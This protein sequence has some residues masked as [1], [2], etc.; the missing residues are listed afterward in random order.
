MVVESCEWAA[1]QE[2]HETVGRH[3]QM[4]ALFA[5]D[6]ERF[7]ALSLSA[8][9]LLLDYSKNIVDGRT[10]SLLFAL[11]RSRKVE[12]Q[13]DAMF[14]GE[15]INVTEDRA[16]L[17]TALR[18][19]GETAQTKGASERA[20]LVEGELRSM[21]R[22][23]QAVRAGQWI[24][25]DGKTAISDVV[26]IG[27]GGSDLGPAMVCTALQGDYGADEGGHLVR[28]HFVSNV[29]GCQLAAVLRAL[30]SPASTLFVVVSKTFTTAE[31]MLNASSARDYILAGFEKHRKSCPSLAASGGAESLEGGSGSCLAKH[32]V[33]VS[34][35]EEAAVAFGVAPCNIVRFWDWVGGRYSLWSA[36]G[37]TIMVALGYDNFLDLL[38]GAHA[39]DR[40]FRE[41][42]LEANMPVIMALIGVYYNNFWRCQTHAVLPYE[43]R[44][45]RFPAYLQQADMESNGKGTTLEGQLIGNAYETGPIVWGEPGTNGQHAFYQLLHQGT[46]V[47][48]AD[49]LIG[50][51]TSA[52]A[53]AMSG[54]KHHRMLAA[55]CFAQS[56][57]LMVGSSGNGDAHKAFPGNRPSNTLVYDRLTPS[58]LGSL[59]ALYEHKIFVQGVI[60]GVN[61]FDQMG[62]E[63]G[64][65]LATRILGELEGSSSSASPADL[66]ALGGHDSSTAAL[67]AHFLAQRAHA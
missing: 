31:T 2:H 44:L 35:N 11:A 48:P 14:A 57:A 54:G 37:L 4:K 34:T 18:A 52:E 26:N 64:K 56:E 24:G 58:T 21:K 25:Y 39:L 49:F 45:A 62:V 41:A 33:A 13:R 67:I 51:K 43:Q 36:A 38:R 61:S 16:V 32:F 7:K 22:I 3:M 17:H 42:P 9:G 5:E 59:I 65:R 12:A 50:C 55:N 63:L 27:I 20:A 15:H 10:M 19:L 40:H 30:P 28:T 46:K 60:W 29:D 1:L 66:A 47:V 8:A 23:A 6:P 53:D